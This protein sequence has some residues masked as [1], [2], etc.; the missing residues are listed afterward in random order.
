MSF[1][2]FDLDPWL[3]DGIAD[4][5]YREPTP[6]QAE[7]IPAVL[8]GRDVLGLAQTGTGK[9][10]AFA[11]PIMER[12][13]DGELGRPR[14]LIV[15]PT[16]ELAEQINR[17]FKLLGRHTDLRT[18]TLY[19]GVG[20]GPQIDA[21]WDG[22]EIV[23]ACPGRLLDHHGNGDLDLS[24]IETLVLDEADLMMD[25]GFLP[26]IKRIISLLPAKRQNLFFS[27]TM[28]GWIRD[29]ADQV[30]V[31]PVTVQVDLRAPAET[32]T[33]ALFPCTD[34]LRLDLL[35]AILTE[36]NMDRVLV[37]AR[38]RQR[39]RSLAAVLE[40]E[41]HNV[42][43]LQGN[44]PQAKRQRALDGFRK[45]KYDILVAT[46][47]ASR[48]I[49]ISDITHVV[50][51]DMPSTVDAYTHRIG[52]T[53]RALKTGTAFTLATQADETLVHRVETVLGYDIDR[54]ILDD[55]DYGAYKPEDQGY[56]RTEKRRG[57]SRSD[58]PG[59]MQA[60]GR[61]RR[62]GAPRGRRISRRG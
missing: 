13:L 16:R 44:M 4:A 49:D 59:G 23:V 11:L 3:E 58:G 39:T 27:A 43:C 15:A 53:G 28:P 46:D 10:A 29:L 52:R 61:I 14:A 6:I 32:V 8:S 45:G 9:T 1:E 2:K 38:T 60:A 62:G 35:K 19:G 42:A 5:G 24:H 20:K 17:D 47:I 55:F 54:R 31:D 57:L 41:N 50:N 12:L 7:A 36:Y 34:R 51:Y 18:V 30:L 56:R 25:M 40:R 22:V 21:L 33:H 37:F 48:G 26:D